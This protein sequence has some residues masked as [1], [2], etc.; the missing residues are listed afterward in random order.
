MLCD[1]Y[2]ILLWRLTLLA[3]RE[4]SRTVALIRIT[5]TIALTPRFH[6][7][8]VLFI[9]ALIDGN[10]VRHRVTGSS[11]LFLGN[12]PTLPLS[13]ALH[14]LRHRLVLS[15]SWFASAVTHNIILCL[16]R[17]KRRLFGI[18]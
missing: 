8:L 6:V 13:Q 4:L 1:S 5:D 10:L 14:V 2:G 7:C 16:L 17:C 15:L 12:L 18:A 9:E 11:A 3:L